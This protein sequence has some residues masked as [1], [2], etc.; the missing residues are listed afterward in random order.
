MSKPTPHPGTFIRDELAARNWTQGDLAF[1]LGSSRSAVGRLVRGQTAI[2]AETADMLAAAFGDEPGLWMRRE[3]DWQLSVIPA[4]DIRAR[5]SRA[6]ELIRAR[7]GI[8]EAAVAWKSGQGE[9]PKGRLVAAVDRYLDAKET[10][11]GD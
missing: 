10:K 11:T 8:T 2:T 7:N 9:N 1:I 4:A 6:S 5:A 3:N